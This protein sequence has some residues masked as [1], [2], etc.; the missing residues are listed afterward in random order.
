MKKFIQTV[1]GARAVGRLIAEKPIGEYGFA[2]EILSQTRTLKQNA[3]IHVYFGL[4]ATDLNNAGFELEMKF[5]GKE[6]LIPWTG[7]LVKE[8]IWK[9]AMLAATGKTSTTKLERKEVSEIYEILS[10][11]FTER[12]GIFVPF[13]EQEH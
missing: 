3:S 8:H 10:R 7:S 13:P 1:E 6:I 2:V 4:L 12:F 5:L 9:P 11:F